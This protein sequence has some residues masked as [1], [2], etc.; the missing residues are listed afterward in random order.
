MRR[1]LRAV[2]IQ[3]IEAAKCG[4]ASRCGCENLS[5]WRNW[6]Q[7]STHSETGA[8]AGP[9]SD[10]VCTRRDET[11]LLSLVDRP[12]PPNLHVS[13]GDVSKSADI[14]TVMEGHDPVGEAVWRIQR[15]RWP[16]SATVQRSITVPEVAE[17]ACRNRVGRAPE[18]TP[19]YGPAI[20][21]TE[22]WKAI[23]ES[24]ARSGE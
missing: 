5:P 4:L 6:Q 21:R 12:V 17:R 22:C 20:V 1:K 7:R 19:F 15:Q 11:K 16:P 13:I 2:I 9:R 8:S 18:K 24:V 14:T 3:A 10:R 23:A